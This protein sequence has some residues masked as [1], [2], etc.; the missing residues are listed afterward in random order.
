M[1]LELPKNNV[2]F[3]NMGEVKN[4]ILYIYRLNNFYNLMYE[5]AYS[6]Y[7]TDKCWYC[8][9]A[10][11][12][13]HG[14]PNDTRAKITLD[15]LIPTSIGGP[16]IVNN[17][18]PACHACNDKE[19][20]D[21]T[22]EQFIE[23]L[24]LKEQLQKCFTQEEKSRLSKKIATRRIE[25]RNENTDKRRGIIP[26][27]PAEW[28]SKKIT[29]DLLGTISPDIQLGSQ[30][31]KQDEFYRK[32]KRIKFPLIISNNGYLLAGYNSVVISKKYRIPWQLE[33]IVLENVVVCLKRGTPY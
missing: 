15:H 33:K 1:N 21:L 11:K 6:V 31:K 3:G 24:F 16:T 20:G 29:G 4:G 14:T 2:V 25:M 13:G 26:Y 5:V 10:C 32:Y 12:R 28:T 8:G 22:S 18:R 23:I 9:K 19:K 27:L 7:G 17:L 30:F